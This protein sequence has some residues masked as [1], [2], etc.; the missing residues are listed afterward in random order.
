MDLSE[1]FRGSHATATGLLTPGVLRGPRFR[2]LFPDVYVRAG[3]DVDLELLSRA[4]YLLVAGHGALGGFSAA[5]LLGASC[6]GLS[7][8]AEVVS[9]YRVRSHA[10]L[11]VRQD[12]IPPD[13][14]QH[15]NGLVVTTPQRTAYDLGRRTPLVEAVVAVDALTHVHGFDAREVLVLARRHLGARGSAQL[16][17]VVELSDR[18]ADSPM[19]TRLRLALRFHGLPLPALQHP[20]GPYELDLAYPAVRIAVE[21]N[22]RDHLAP[23]RAL[24]DLERE[25]YLTAAGWIVLRFGAYLVL[26]RPDLVAARVRDRLA[27]AARSAGLPLDALAAA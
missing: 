17:Q 26:R 19:E 22:G 23:D 21:Y 10:G 8:P 6:A 27:A 12:R 24:H 7:A 2:R 9:P 20:V 3:T 14:L 4:A 16:P 18:R 15:L 25:A 11:L 1:P 13:E 5:E